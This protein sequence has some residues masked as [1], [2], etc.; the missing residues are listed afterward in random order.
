GTSLVLKPVEPVSLNIAP[1]DETMQS[2]LDENPQ[3]AAATEKVQQ[4]KAALTAAKSA[5]IP[6][7][8]VFARHSYQNGVPFLIHNFGTFG[9]ALSYDVFDFGKRRAVVREREAQLAQAEEN[10][11]RLKDA[12]GVQIE[13]SLNKVERTKHMVQVASELVRLRTE[14]DRVAGN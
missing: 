6:D 3:I 8:S 5:Y 12:V 1:R 7:V 13:R 2:A 9:A 14:A 11:E 10:V 4:A